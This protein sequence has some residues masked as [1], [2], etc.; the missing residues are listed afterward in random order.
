MRLLLVED[1]ERLARGMVASLEAAGFAVDILTNGEDA[2]RLVGQEPYCAI[3]LDLGLP[4]MDGL[5]VL[6]RL[7]A[8]G[9]TTP[10][11]ILTARDMVDDRING[12]DRGADD[13]M[14]K[15]FDPR[16]LESRIRALVRRSQGTPDPVLRIGALA[17]DRSSR[18]VY[19][20]DHVLD[21]RRRELA[22][23]ETLMGRPGKVVAKERLSAEIFNFDDAVTPNALEVYVGRLRRKLQPS[24]PAI[25]TIRGLGYMIEA[26]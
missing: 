20:D 15:P 9:A 24:G 18:T 19:L 16:E 1:D 4:D 21:L 8:R 12:L 25:R 6:S 22:V 10:V 3:V 13:Y 14:A 11:L 17:F 23:L 7:R 5:D 2:L 26:A